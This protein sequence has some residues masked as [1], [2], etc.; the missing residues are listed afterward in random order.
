MLVTGAVI[1]ETIFAWPGVGKY[2]LDAVDQMDYPVVMAVLLISSALVI[3]GNLL[4]DLLYPLADP[5]ARL[6]GAPR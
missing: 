6:G 2:F 4:A 3:I 1:T 5:R